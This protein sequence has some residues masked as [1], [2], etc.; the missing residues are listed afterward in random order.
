M[1]YSLVLYFVHAG[2]TTNTLLISLSDI[3]ATSVINDPLWLFSQPVM[4]LHTLLTW[5]T[6]Y[7][8]LS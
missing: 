2:D 7:L 6:G 5:D 3:P 4:A 8:R 1:K